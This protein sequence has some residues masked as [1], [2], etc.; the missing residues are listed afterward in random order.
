MVLLLTSVAAELGGI[1]QG[2]AVGSWKG[3]WFINLD[4]KQKKDENSL[5]LKLVV[6]HASNTRP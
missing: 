4:A 1:S 5:Y 2:D 6:P 3:Q